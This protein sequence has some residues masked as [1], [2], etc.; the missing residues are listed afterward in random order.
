MSRC[1]PYPPPGYEPRPRS[2]LKDLLKK[3][4][5]K[6]KKHKKEN[7]RD[8]GERKQKFREK[9]ERK[10]KDRDHKKLKREKRRERRK[11][12]NRDK[13]N[14]QTMKKETQKNDDFGNRRP[15]E[16][17]QNEAVKDIKRADE[18]PGQEVH[19]NHKV[20]S[21]SE[22][23]TRSAKGIG[24]TASKEESSLSRMVKKS[25]HAA[26]H[27]HWMVQKNDGTAHT[28]KKG[29]ADH[30]GSKTRL[31]NG[32]SPQVGSGE[33]HSSRRHSGKLVDLLQDNSYTQ[34]SSEGVR[35]ANAVVSEGVRDAKAVVS[36]A[37][38]EPNGRVTP[39]PNTL[40]RAE[41]RKDSVHSNTKDLIRKGNHSSK[42]HHGN[43]DLQLEQITCDAV[44]GEAKIKQVKGNYLKCVEGKDG[45]QYVKKRKNNSSNK[46][47]TMERSGDLNEQN[48]VDRPMASDDIKKRKNLD[49]NSSLRE[50]GM[51]TTK[52][53]RMSPT[54]ITCVNGK[55]TPYSQRTAPYPSSELAGGNAQELDW[56]NPQD[57]Y[58]NG[59]TASHYLEQQ[60]VYVSSSGDDSNKGY[61]KPSHLDTMYLS[62]VYSIPPRGDISENIDQDWLFSENH[63]ERN[64]ATFEAAESQEVWSHAH[65]I[66]TADVVAFPYVVPL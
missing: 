61:P 19:T 8:K 11:S 23:L 22:L 7:D 30:V 65:L 42:N 4:S 62:Q 35:D 46:V 66:D 49:A 64:T 51:K 17:R 2:E 48:K 18:F 21:T 25:G 56:H 47:K 27:Y 55:V 59:I 52:L 45:D 29:M 26:Q 15:E 36:G 50:H 32:K 14:H 1:F 63:V 57:G 9:G 53:P 34:R 12:N 16:R 24:A 20:N 31:K 13:Q 5:H 58:R 6:G 28:D 41:G 3:E 40:Q 43:T 33:K 54:N 39:S 10:G 60:K 37:G 38:T 44:E